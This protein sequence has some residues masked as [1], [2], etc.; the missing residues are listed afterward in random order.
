MDVRLILHLV[1]TLMTSISDRH[2]YGFLSKAPESANAFA[3]H[4]AFLNVLNIDYMHDILHTEPPSETLS[5]ALPSDSLKPS[6]QDITK[7]DVQ[8]VT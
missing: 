2:I 3:Q 1:C 5:E 7:T 4:V 6:V 8:D